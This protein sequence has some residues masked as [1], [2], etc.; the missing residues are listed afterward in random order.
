MSAKRDL[1]YYKNLPYKIILEREELDEETWFIAYAQELGKYA[2]YGQGD[3]PEEALKSFKEEKEAFIE[4]L[5]IEKKNIPEPDNTL[6]KFSGTFT[7]R[8]SPVIHANLVSQAQKMNISLNLYLNQILSAAVERKDFENQVFNKIS[9]LSAKFDAHHS[10]VTN[11]LKFQ[12]ENINHLKW[13]PD[14][15]IESP[16]LQTT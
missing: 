3:T 10:A 14:Y 11:Q 9:E 8:T 6:E 5:Y 4:Y 1:N 13:H 15:S 12:S 7:V 16:Y 2:C